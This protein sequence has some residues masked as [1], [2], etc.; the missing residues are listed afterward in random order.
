MSFVALHLVVDLA[1][2][3]KSS[4]FYGTHT[5][6]V[7]PPV[8]LWM[9]MQ[10]VCCFTTVVSWRKK[11]SKCKMMH[12][13]LDGYSF[14]TPRVQERS[15]SFPFQLW[16]SLPESS[17][18]QAQDKTVSSR[19]SASSFCLLLVLTDWHSWMFFCIQCFDSVVLFTDWHS[20]ASQ[21]S[22]LQAQPHHWPSS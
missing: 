16:H 18:L 20:M 21:S 11:A 3:N 8:F 19:F 13:Q 9:Q 1:S 10:V 12:G 4:S 7:H 17:H 6:N 14:S 5:P 22:L 15:T 2:P